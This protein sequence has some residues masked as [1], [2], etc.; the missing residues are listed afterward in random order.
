LDTYVE[1]LP[2]ACK[3]QPLMILETYTTKPV[4][5]AEPQLPAFLEVEREI[6]GD[7]AYSMFDLNHFLI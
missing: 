3:G 5:D 6:T 7:P 1:P 2:P 4:H